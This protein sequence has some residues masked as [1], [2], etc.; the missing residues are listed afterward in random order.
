MFKLKHIDQLPSLIIVAGASADERV[1]FVLVGTL[2]AEKRLFLNVRRKYALGT[3]RGEM[4]CDFNK[5]LA[6]ERFSSAQ[7]PAAPSVIR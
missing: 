2:A 7:G 1:R 5:A 3:L 4:S 6:S